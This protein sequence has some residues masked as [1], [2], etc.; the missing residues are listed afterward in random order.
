M[1]DKK[2]G[3][4][5]SWI[6]LFITVGLT[7]LTFIF[8]PLIISIIIFAAVYLPTTLYILIYKWI[9]RW[10]AALV[11]SFSIWLNIMLIIIP[12]IGGLVA[13]DLMSFSKDLAEDPKY[14]I[15]DDNGLIF[16]MSL[17]SIGLIGEQQT[18]NR[19][20][21]TLT[22]DQLAQIQND[23]NED[24]LENKIV[25]KIEKEFFRNIDEIQIE[26]LGITATKD[27]IITM[28]T[29]EDPSA[30]L[31]EK[32]SSTIGVPGLELDQLGDIDNEQI[33]TMAFFLLIQKT[34]EQEGTD[35]IIKE[36]KNDN[37]KIYPEKTSLKMLIKLMPPE[38]L[39]S[40]L[41]DIS[42]LPNTEVSN[43]GRG[44]GEFGNKQNFG[45]SNSRETQRK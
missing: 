5:A 30:I 38:I 19:Q 31:E 35:Y 28:L 36:L 40:L 6:I 25:F 20:S 9:D 27:E 44:Q 3:L 13:L 29:A 37:I 39:S 11:F 7:I 26:Q 16:G 17:D 12:L 18:G 2:R 34:I 15:L 23:I 22:I 43:N 32:L 8:L 42:G 1:D 4:G 21:P 14:I 33:K 10:F 24:T 45:P 41:P